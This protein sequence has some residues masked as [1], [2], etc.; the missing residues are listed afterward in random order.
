[1]LPA[2]SSMP[3]ARL[4]FT[5]AADALSDGPIIELASG[6]PLR[7]MI[8]VLTVN[9]DGSPPHVALS[10]I[11]LNSE[12]IPS[13]FMPQARALPLHII[14]LGFAVNTALAAALWWL[15]LFAFPTTRRLL[16][17]RRGAC[18]KC[19]YG[20]LGTDGC[21]ECGWNRSGRASSAP[22]CATG[23]LASD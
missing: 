2:W 8:S 23:A 15:L 16:R 9:P 12:P 18:L 20:P 6:W 13:H 21:P 11:P 3:E 19:G 22:S 1:M 10:G 17:H 7:S 14:P 4:R 5:K